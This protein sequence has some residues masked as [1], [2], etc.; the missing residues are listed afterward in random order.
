MVFGQQKDRGGRT[1]VGEAPGDLAAVT[2][3]QGIISMQRVIDATGVAADGT[4]STSW[5][6]SVPSGSQ[7]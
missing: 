6:A 5:A 3:T 7:F 1:G 2:P 4:D